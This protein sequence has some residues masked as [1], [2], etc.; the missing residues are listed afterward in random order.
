MSSHRSLSPLFTSSLLISAASLLAAC[1]GSSKAVKP[2]DVSG[3]YIIAI[4]DADMTATA[5]ST[6]DLGERNPLAKDTLTVVTL[7]IQEPN[8]PFAQINVS[9]S[10]LC[11][12]TCLSVTRDGRYAFVVDHRGP[13]GPEA[14]RVEDLPKGETVAAIDLTQPLNP[15]VSAM[16]QVGISP[17]A[18][19]VN[20]RGDLLAIAASAPRHQIVIVPTLQGEFSGEP[21]AWPLLGLDDDEAVPSSIA[22]HPAGHALAVT[23]QSRGEVMFYRFKRDSSGDMAVAPWGKPVAVGKSPYSGAFTPDGRFFIVN[24]LMWGSD[25]DGYNVGAPPGRLVVIDV[26]EMAA[27]LD[28]PLAEDAQH[29]V[30]GVANTG[31]SPIG[32]AISNDGRLIATANMQR[33]HLPD[34]DPRLAGQPRGGSVSLLSL[35]PDG[36]LTPAGEYPINA[37][38][39]GI[40]FDAADR[41]LCVTQF[42]SF[43]ADATDGELAFWKVRRGATPSLEGAD[44]FVG[45]GA[46]P[47][48]VLIVR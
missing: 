39:A 13:A 19:G 42:R 23:L 2:S 15:R 18:V 6:G 32:M 12:P 38:P 14:R 5:F 26:S 8:T 34:N 40:S 33:S 4:G 41:F 28:S 16:A 29:R 17:V 22:W 48:G 11:P 30:I 27:G 3:R 25:V 43:D 45:V 7:P 1:G 31:V 36:S 46:G 44:F 21:A 24:D 47:H 37:M 20:A 35:S 9:N 10:A